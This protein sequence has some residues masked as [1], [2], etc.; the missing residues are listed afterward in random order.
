MAKLSQNITRILH[1]KLHH[2]NQEDLE[3]LIKRGFIDE[4]SALVLFQQILSNTEAAKN[5]A[6]SLKND[7]YI[8]NF[9]PLVYS[10]HICFL[11]LSFAFSLVHKHFTLRISKLLYVLI[12]LAEIMFFYFFALYLQ[13]NDCLYFSSGVHVIFDLTVYHLLLDIL[14]MLGFN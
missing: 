13:S 14:Q 4:A 1:E 12:K 5:I 3:Y 9:I 8:G 7:L 11:S 2:M 10:L 6:Y